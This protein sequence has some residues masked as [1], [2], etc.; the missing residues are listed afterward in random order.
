MNKVAKLVCQSR[1]EEPIFKTL[2]RQVEDATRK[3]NVLERFEI[4]PGREDLKNA[5]SYVP[6]NL[7]HLCKEKNDVSN[8]GWKKLE[9]WANWW[10]RS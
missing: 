4:L 2:A 10:T 8:D 5:T 1:H 7:K 9:H 6:E 3:E